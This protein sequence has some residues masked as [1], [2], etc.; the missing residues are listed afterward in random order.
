MDLPLLN[1]RDLDFLLYEVLDTEALLA[2]SRYAEHSRADFAAIFATARTIAK[3]HFADHNAKGDANE[4]R[5]EG[6]RVVLI[7]ETKIAW[8][9]FAQAGFLAM[10]ESFDNG[11]LQLPEVIARSCMAL[12]SAA[13][14]AT[15]AYPFLSLAAANLIRSF[16]S[17]ELKARFLPHLQ[18][19]RF[20]G[21]MA[22][23]EPNQGSA[24]ADITTN[25]E[26]RS[27][28]HYRLRG[29]KMFISGG[30]Q[31]ITE[32]IIHLVL[33]K[34][35]GAPAGVNGISLFM[36]PKFLVDASGVIGARNDVALAGLLHK[37]GY[38]NTT[39]TVLSFG[40]GEGAVGYLVGE[41]NLGLSYMFQMMNEA[42]IGVGLGA[43]VLA[44][45]G[46]N[47][48]LDYARE[49]R[50]GR[51]AS[52]KNPLSKQVPIIAHSDVRRLLLMQKVYAEGALALCLYASSLFEDSHTAADDTARREAADLLDLLT[53]VVKSWPSKYGLK[54]N[55]LSIQV[56]GG[57]G[58]TR[59]FP[60]EQLYRDQRLNPIH[61]GTEGIQA[62][63]LLGR[64]VLK[65]A[66]LQL[67]LR[68]VRS[69]IEA[70]SQHP[71]TAA[72]A[73]SLTA[74]LAPLERVTESLR[75]QIAA[76]I[77]AGLAN[78]SLYLDVFGR[79]VVAWLWLRQAQ[80]AAAGLDAGAASADSSAHSTADSNF[81]RGKLQAA[82]FFLRWELPEIEPQIALLEAGERTCFEMKDEW[83]NAP[84]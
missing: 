76:D 46:F 74:A 58:Y 2:R 40:E 73:L 63:D 75:G 69:D 67:L 20:A 57:A 28:G 34:V 23:T 71:A 55:E 22:L 5:F 32:N 24:L 81:Y 83:F 4:P 80:S 42:R 18:S 30:D 9:A 33:A 8:D 36:V 39:S 17:P 10:S 53:P 25:A 84:A 1:E 35:K 59:E 29:Q 51:L 64:K 77:D 68:R 27:D 7:D 12:F 13:N 61:E 62:L 47:A 72:L 70:A 6:G 48:A 26:R 65:P 38:R 43:A 3:R 50:Q 41:E 54:G 66:K 15:T 82:Q 31:S 19:G 49:R 21:T 60:V 79:V 14:I 45:Q 78:A 52:N 11:G 16:A 56:F 37:M 44:Y